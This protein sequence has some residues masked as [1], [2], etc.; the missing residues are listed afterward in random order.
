MR[1]LLIATHG[2][3]AKGILS[4]AEIIAGKKDGVVCINAYSEE[5]NIQE[6]LERYFQSVTEQD[7]VIVLSDLFGG[8]VNQALMP[9]TKRGNVHLLTG[10]NLAL[11]LELLMM[12]EEKKVTEEELRSLA[13]GSRQQIMYVNDVLAS[14]YEDDFDEGEENII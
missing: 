8:S 11:L 7:Q 12:D 2:S 9:Y 3:F 1:K 10:M 14:S 4:A 13:E 5:K 6:A